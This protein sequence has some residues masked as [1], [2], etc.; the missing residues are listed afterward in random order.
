[1][2][3]VGTPIGNLQDITLRALQILRDVD[4]ILAEDTRHTRRLLA[5]HNIHTPLSSLHAHSSPAR[6][7]RVLEELAQGA[8]FALVSDAGS[9]LISDPGGV[10]VEQAVQRGVHIEPVPGP[11][12]V[13]SAL[14]V[15]GFAFSSFHFF[16]FIPRKGARRRQTMQRIADDEAAAVLFEAAPR[17]KATL[18]ELSQYIGTRRI[19][20]C[21]E[22]TKLHEQVLRGE[23]DALLPQLEEL[24]GEVTLV[25]ESQKPTHREF[26]EALL[27]QRIEVLKQQGVSARDAARQLSNEF[28]LP[29]R[30]VYQ[31]ILRHKPTEPH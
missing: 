25:I 27:R 31:R 7:Q 18:Q 10:L 2:S 19:A 5:R 13:I 29:R 15:C 9:P 30:D 12:A 17:L 20:I 4:R 8:W 26:P 1:M 21:R 28:S 6:V 3:I 16:G 23:V 22:L 11:S 14:S 24:R